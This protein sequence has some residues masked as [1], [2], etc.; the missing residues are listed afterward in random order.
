[1]EHFLLK[2]AQYQNRVRKSP[3]IVL[4][5][6]GSKSTLIFEWCWIKSWENF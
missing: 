3:I 4:D 1:M 6:R 5:W 2:E